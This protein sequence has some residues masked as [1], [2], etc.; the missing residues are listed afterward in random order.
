M[1]NR[2]EWLEYQLEMVNLSEELR[3]QYNREADDLASR[4]TKQQEKT[5]ATELDKQY[6]IACIA[7]MIDSNHTDQLVAA[8]GDEFVGDYET[9]REGT[10]H[11][12]YSSVARDD[13][14]SRW[15]C[16]TEDD[17]KAKLKQLLYYRIYD[18]YY[19][20]RYNEA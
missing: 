11:V 16:P 9:R 1:K 12:I 6:K 5:K 10:E 8:Y 13:Q 14:P 18:H 20:E 4:E 15:P 2:L 7:D 3:A 19:R 17:A